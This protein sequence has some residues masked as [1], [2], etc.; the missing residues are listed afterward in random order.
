[1][2][3]NFSSSNGHEDVVILLTATVEVHGVAYMARQDP[4]V[5]LNDY[6]QALRLWLKT[7][8]SFPLI[9]C[10]NSGYNLSEIEQIAQ[11]CNPYNKKVEFLSFNDNDYPR[12]LGKGYGEIRTIGY[13][14][15]YSQL[16][17]PDTLVIKVTGRHYVQNIG[18]IVNGLRKMPKSEVYCDMR[19]NLTWADSR[20]FCS[21]IPFIR[22]LLIPMQETCNDTAGI[23]IEHV[24]ARAAHQCLIQGQSWAMLPCFPDIRGVSGTSG[25]VYPS[26]FLNR[27]KR[28]FFYRLKA[29][30]LARGC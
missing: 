15:N 13:A 11:N 5:R 26:S 24:L 22:N 25:V 7:S 19:G 16:L 28:S 1:M 29:A 20:V 23:T 3:H 27:L 14:L 6:K 9:F 8:G 30:V 17:R 12:G 21:T 18:C 10:E 2:D 4:K